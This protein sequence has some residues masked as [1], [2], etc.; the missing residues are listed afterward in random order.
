M[1]LQTWKNSPDGRIL[2]ADVTVAKNYLQ[3]DEIKRLERT[4]SG[5]FD[6]VEN[7]IQNRTLI[8]MQSMSESVDKF[9]SFDR[10]SK[11]KSI[12]PASSATIVTL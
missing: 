1:G 7:I 10:R 8:T 12:S 2:S 3:E 11:I 6:Y 9:I 4:I 5:F